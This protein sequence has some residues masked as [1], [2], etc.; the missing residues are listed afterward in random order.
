MTGRQ[1]FAAAALA[2]AASPALADVPF[3]TDDP[4]IIDPGHYEVAFS[5]D[6]LSLPARDATFAAASLDVGIADGAQAGVATL[7][8]QQGGIAIGELSAN[9]KIAVLPASDGRF[10]LAFRPALAIPLNNAIRSDVGAVLPL[11]GGIAA[12][13]WSIY[14]GGGYA[15]NSARD[16][17]SYPVGGLV[18]SRAVGERWVLGGELGARGAN[19]PA[20]SF[21]EIGAGASV[22][23]GRYVTLA[24]ALYRTLTHR[25][26][27]GD[28]RAF[29]TLRYAR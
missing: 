23:L 28:G 17:G 22:A 19:D 11:Y 10:G 25:G 15:I 7:A 3:L 5:L 8:R 4:F 21:V 9:V 1:L 29:V 13:G 16:G 26:A 24:G 18:V 2:S 6:R 20:P 14:G 27:N 12:G